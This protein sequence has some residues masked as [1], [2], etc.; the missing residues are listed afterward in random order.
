MPASTDGPTLPLHAQ[1]PGSGQKNPTAV[2][3]VMGTDGFTF[4]WGLPCRSLEVNQSGSIWFRIVYIYIYTLPEMIVEVYNIPLD[5]HSHSETGGFPLP[6]P[7]QG[8]ENNF[9]AVRGSACPGPCRT[10]GAARA[11]S[12][13]SFRSRDFGRRRPWRPVGGL[14]LFEEVHRLFV[15]NRSVRTLRAMAMHPP[16]VTRRKT[17]NDRGV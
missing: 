9:L 12:A 3:I 1:L 6:R 17:S 5:D 2:K 14:V 7:V 16:G 11:M 15:V 10:T 4:F 13:L 8:V